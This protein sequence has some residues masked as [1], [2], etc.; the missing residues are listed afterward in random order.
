MP[1]RFLSPRSLLA[2]LLIGVA[3]LAPSGCG[4]P[5]RPRLNPP[6]Q[7]E[8]TAQPEWGRCFDYHDDQGML[9]DMSIAD[10]HFVPHS[11]ELSGTGEARLERYAELL[12]RTGGRIWY[13]SSLCEPSLAEARLAAA[14]AF[15]K[16]ALPT[17]KTIEV[18]FGL[19]GG[20]G[21]SSKAASAAKVIA[22]Q[23]EPRSTAYKLNDSQDSGG[24][25]R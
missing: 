2:V 7:G 12:A 10:I 14:R 13:D 3:N 19:P 18:A 15:L 5:T 20:R 22:E 9:A 11:A 17:A 4:Q 21:M 8:A 24:A 23:P 25:K 16:D 1:P 6:S